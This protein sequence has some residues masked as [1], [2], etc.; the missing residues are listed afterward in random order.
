MTRQ[1]E[2]AQQAED[3]IAS[4]KESL[5]RGEWEAARRAF[6]TSAGLCETPAALEGLSDAFFSLHEPQSSLEHRSRA[7]TLYCEAG[8]RRAAARVALWVAITYLSAYSNRSAANGWVQR[9]ERLI[10]EGDSCADRGLL[11]VLHACIAPDPQSAVR[12]AREAVTIA[13]QYND[14]DVE[15]WALSEEGR[16]LVMLGRVDEGMELLDEATAA[17]TVGKRNLFIVGMTCCNMLSACDRATDFERAMQWCQVVEEFSR[18]HGYPL[19]S[20]YCRVVYSGVLMGTG[21]WGEAEEELQGALGLLGQRFPA[22]SVFSLSRLALLRVHQGRLEEADQLLTGLEGH[23]AAIEVTASL[24]IA[25]G[26]AALAASLL[27]R[28]LEAVGELL[29]AV[30]LLRLLVEASLVAGNVDRARAAAIKLTELAD[31]SKCAPMQALAL[32]CNARVELAGGGL[33]HS[34]FDRACVLF[35]RCGMVFEAARTRLEWARA[36]AATDRELAAEDARLACAAFERM[37]ARSYAD[38]A[39]ALVRELGGGTRPGPRAGEDLTRREREVLGLLSH[40]MSNGEI[41]DRLFISPKTVEHHVGR[42]LS[43]LGL[44]NRAEAATWAL[45]NPAAKMRI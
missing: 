16:M 32:M 17:A 15:V 7:Y 39:A 34:L 19:F 28:R 30:P 25:R 24:S 38:Q 20:H 11:E 10:D 18:R 6:E 1:N 3:L 41:G 5:A 4:G 44:R 29:A 35:E 37:G 23:P 26:Q 42:I 36:L 27:E 14:G 45:R 40:G 2:M 33:S 13:R 43:K 8:D 9:A 12:H 31:R 21:R 22:E